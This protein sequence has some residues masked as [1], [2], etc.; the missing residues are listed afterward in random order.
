MKRRHTIEFNNY[1]SLITNTL[2]DS[3]TADGRMSEVIVGVK[4]ALDN[5]KIVRTAQILFEDWKCIRICTRCMI[6][7]FL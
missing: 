4:E 1:V 7:I 6:K 2:Q 5:P 3:N